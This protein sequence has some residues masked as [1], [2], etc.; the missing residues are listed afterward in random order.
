MRVLSAR[1]PVMNI[2]LVL[3]GA[4]PACDWISLVGEAGGPTRP[5]PGQ[6]PS[7]AAI[8]DGRPPATPDA[9]VTADS[10]AP[11]DGYD[12]MCR[13]YCQALEETDLL[14]CTSTGRPLDECQAISPTADSC[15]DLRCRP[16]RVDVALCLRQCDSLRGLYDGRCSVEPSSDPLCPAPP[17]EHDAAC[18]ASCML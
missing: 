14:G 2:G 13:H 16:R 8:L 7:D 5:P 9:G 3:A 11:G 1:G 12:A 6:P 4:G 15:F 18:R 10:G 17:A